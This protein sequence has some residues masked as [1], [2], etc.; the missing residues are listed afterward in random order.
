MLSRKTLGVAG[1]A[2][3]GSVALLVTNSANAQIN[4]DATDK[5]S[6]AV[7]YAQELLATSTTHDGKKYY[8]VTDT[9]GAAGTGMVSA[10]LGVAVTSGKAA[11]VTYIFENMVFLGATAPA[12]SMADAA[13]VAVPDT[14]ATA[15]IAAGGTSGLNEVSYAI[16]SASAQTLPGTTVLTL[17]FPGDGVGISVVDPVSITMMVEADPI[18]ST[19]PAQMH[20]AS[21]PNAIAVKSGIAVT[22]NTMSQ[23]ASVEEGFRKFLADD[24]VTEDG[25]SDDQLTV[26]LGTISVTEN[27]TYRTPAGALVTDNSIVTD[28]TTTAESAADAT[29]ADS[30]VVINGDFAFASMA[31]L[32]NDATCT[33]NSRTNLI[34]S[35][36]KSK[37]VTQGLGFVNGKH[38]CI[39]VSGADDAMQIPETVPYEAEITYVFATGV[40][41][42]MASEMGSALYG[43]IGRDGATVRIPYLTTD[44]RYNQRIVIVNRGAPAMYSMAFT[45][46]DGITTRAGMAASGEL[47]TGTT[48]FKTIDAVTIM[49]G[50]PHRASGTISVVATTGNISVATNQTNK[51]DGSTD[52]VVY[53]T[54]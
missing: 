17:A 2:I 53:T 52:T 33:G 30:S 7:T 23:T 42:D 25:V 11:I 47:P 31:V 46:E 16:A 48:V 8:T 32:E 37:L 5:S 29:I 22:R 38:L 12:L 41:E 18:I 26:S 13:G 24:D 35:D 50:P 44:E 51:M 3:L 54:Q 1:A 45:S 19:R 36:D 28:D 40:N 34:M 9:D 39:T 21:H 20:E 14:S 43:S 4:L 6:A 10:K 27:L 49:G 15:T